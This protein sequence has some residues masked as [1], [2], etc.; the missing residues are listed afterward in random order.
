[1]ENFISIG[2][3]QQLQGAGVDSEMI[4]RAIENIGPSNIKIVSANLGETNLEVFRAATSSGL[5]KEQAVWATPLGKTMNA[6]GFKSVE[7]SGAGSVSFS[8]FYNTLNR[9]SPR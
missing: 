9:G 3:L 4:S 7:M 2:M 5:T 6:L 8:P 1:M